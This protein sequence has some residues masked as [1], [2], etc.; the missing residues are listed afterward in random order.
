MYREEIDNDVLA[1][2]FTYRDRE[3]VRDQFTENFTDIINKQL[4]VWNIFFSHCNLRILKACFVGVIDLYVLKIWKLVLT[5]LVMKILTLKLFGFERSVKCVM[6]VRSKFLVSLCVRNCDASQKIEI[7]HKHRK[8]LLLKYLYKVLVVF[9]FRF[10]SARQTWKTSIG[11]RF[12][13][14]PHASINFQS[15]NYSET[16]QHHV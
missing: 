7:F 2:I 9:L 11:K 14:S 4:K 3:L 8:A 16:P 15:L 13:Y 5:T 1:L 6:C 10:P 12:P